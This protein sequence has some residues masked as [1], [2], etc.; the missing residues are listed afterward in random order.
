M[1]NFIVVVDQPFY[2]Y[3]LEFDNHS[4]AERA[5]TEEIKDMHTED[6]HYE[7]TV[8]MAHVHEEADIQTEY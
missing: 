4:D 3:V 6:G 5:W 8:Y 1:T 2:P 7:G